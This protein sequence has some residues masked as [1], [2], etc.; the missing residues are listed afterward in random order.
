MNPYRQANHAITGPDLASGQTT[1][2]A[3]HGLEVVYY[4][5][6]PDGRIKIGTS[7]DVLARLNRHR[8][9]WGNV[10]VLAI[11]FG[12]RNLER[13]RHLE[14][15]EYLAAGREIFTPGPR[16]AEHLKALQCA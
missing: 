16:L 1:R 6:L 11:E 4:L 12:G 10:T 15:A 8:K 13:Q 2:Q 9:R 7:T 14:F 5:R 3:T